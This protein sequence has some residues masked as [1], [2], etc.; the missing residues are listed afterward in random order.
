MAVSSFGRGSHSSFEHRR[1][2]ALFH[3]PGDFHRTMIV[4]M[5]AVRMVK[6]AIDQ[7]VD[8][9]TMRHRLMAAA[10]T[11]CVLRVMPRILGHV[12]TPLGVRLANGKDVFYQLV[13]FLMTEVAVVQEIDV[14]V[15]F[16]RRMTA[17]GTMSMGVLRHDN[18]LWQKGK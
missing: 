16:N 13:A 2:G 9:I 4:A 15:V 6:F 5:V 18:L 7:V 3:G 11:M 10:R 14:P 1:L 12:M 17:T 8:V